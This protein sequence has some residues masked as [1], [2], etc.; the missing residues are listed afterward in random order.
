MSSEVPSPNA[1]HSPTTSAITTAH[2]ARTRHGLPAA[3]PPSWY[4]VDFCDRPGGDMTQSLDTASNQK[5]WVRRPQVASARVMSRHG[6][7]DT[8]SSAQAIAPK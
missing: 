8:G 4:S 5:P 1:A 7:I 6:R 3:N 2:P